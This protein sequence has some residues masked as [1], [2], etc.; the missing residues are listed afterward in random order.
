MKKLLVLLALTLGA[1]AAS[2]T[3][4]G[5]TGPQEILT[6]TT[7]TSATCSLQLYF[8]SGL[9]QPVNDTNPSIFTGSNSCT[10]QG[11]IGS[12]PGTVTFVA[13]QRT[14]GLGADSAC[15]ERSLPVDTVIYYQ[16]TADSGTQSGSFR[17]PVVQGNT[18]PEPA[19][20][21]ANCPY[22][23]AYPTIR[24]QVDR[25]KWFTDPTTGLRVS[26]FTAPEPVNNNGRI[27]VNAA[28]IN[29]FDETGNGNWTVAGVGGSVTAS[30]QDPLFVRLA[31]WCVAAGTAYVQAPGSTMGCS[32]GQSTWTEPGIDEPSYNSIDDVQV[33][34]TLTCTGSTTSAQIALTLD[35]VTPATD[36]EGLSC[37]S[38]PTPYLYPATGTASGGTLTQAGFPATLYGTG[39]Y[40]T[41]FGY[42]FGNPTTSRLTRPDMQPHTG[43]VTIGAGCSVTWTA[44]EQFRPSS[45]SVGS[46]LTLLV[47]GTNTD[48]P[49]TAVNS[50]TSLTLGSCPST[51]S[52]GY[53]YQQFGLLVRKASAVSGTL[54]VA[55]VLDSDFESASNEMPI[56]GTV[57][58]CTTYTVTD[59]SGNVLRLCTFAEGTYH[60]VYAVDAQTG[61]GAFLGL[62]EPNG[63]CSSGNCAPGVTSTLNNYYQPFASAVGGTWLPT[64]LHWIMA[65]TAPNAGSSQTI[66][67]GSYN[68]S[69]S[70]SCPNNYQE[71]SPVNCSTFPYNN[72]M[73]W[74]NATPKLG[75]DGMDHSPVTMAT[76]YATAHSLSGFYPA[77][78]NQYSYTNPVDVINGWVEL[79]FEPNNQNYPGWF[80]KMDSASGY[81]VV[82]MGNT[83]MNYGCRFCGSHGSGSLSGYEGIS[84]EPQLPI[85]SGIGCGPMVLQTSTSTDNSTENTCSGITDPNFTSYNGLSKCFDL[86]L[87]GS[88]PCHT[89][90]NGAEVAPMY[91]TCTWDGSYT[92]LTGV[93]VAVGDLLADSSFAGSSGSSGEMFRV[94]L[95]P[96]AG[97]IR[98]I[99]AYATPAVTLG[100][101]APSS[102]LTAHTAPWQLTELCSNTAGAG[103]GQTWWN[104]NTDPTA[105]NGIID[106][107]A[108]LTAHLDYWTSGQW[109]EVNRYR[110]YSSLGAMIAQPNSFEGNDEGTFA[111]F[112]GGGSGSWVQSHGAVSRDSTAPRYKVDSQPY[113]N[114]SIASNTLWT[115]TANL[116]S[117]C[118]WHI[119][120]ANVQTNSQAWPSTMK[121]IPYVMWSGDYLL[122]DISGPSSTISSTCGGANTWNFCIV[123]VANECASGSSVGDIYANIPESGHNGTCGPWDYSRNICGTL[124]DNI[125]TMY[126]QYNWTGQA[127]GQ[128]GVTSCPTFSGTGFRALSRL[129][130]R[131]N[132]QSV[133]SSSHSGFTGQVVYGTADF[134]GSGLRSDI[135]VIKLPALNSTVITRT[136]FVSIP[137]TAAS[138]GQPNARLTWGYEEDEQPT[139][140]TCSQGVQIGSE[141]LFASQRQE[142][143]YSNPSASAP[144]PY[145]Y[146]SDTGQ[147]YTSCSTGCTLTLPLVPER[148][149]YYEIQHLNSGG[150]VI[151]TE[152][153]FVAYDSGLY[154]SVSG[155][156]SSG[157]AVSNG[158]SVRP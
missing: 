61:T 72:N 96:S 99:R 33:G 129:F 53:L 115:Q 137:I 128:C 83:Y 130:N 97:V 62:M 119:A 50:T 39:T 121:S 64:Q 6:I 153:P 144:S 69:G 157:N 125:S 15:H 21:N 111:S 93:T 116:V 142:S 100:E 30:V 22:N 35:G 140:S 148:I 40:Q 82:G 87:S 146:A 155:S 9:T 112:S 52:Y 38:T 113:S 28:A 29:A 92:N 98:V 133:F 16:L 103:G 143:V 81:A 126:N 80:L 77:Q 106:Y 102:T 88:D 86:T 45:V 85:C 58:I 32:G 23:Y 67:D 122:Q 11:S 109:E 54:T 124:L 105:Q 158:A 59:S 139:G 95:I 75:S 108:L 55:T 27:V 78:L 136:G 1:H 152:G 110:D 149:A 24:P 94:V 118:L 74:I 104:L 132:F 90:P 138:T 127:T 151:S 42:W 60:P 79:E 20:F 2:I 107:P 26:M 56:S 46:E 14:S 25:N 120:A 91:G 135:F 37:N 18:F 66:I 13:G 43:T 71:I 117:G 44:G 76:N 89:T 68:P 4:V 5:P 12:V 147:T 156:V 114:V 7:T 134:Y 63:G 48:Y 10:R 34:A 17:T 47:S 41:T 101:S 123:Y 145:Y 131:Y 19:P 8:D 70:G 31:P 36:W 150:S 3:V 141:C 84:T 57:E 51:G 154:T 73:T 49:I 65:A